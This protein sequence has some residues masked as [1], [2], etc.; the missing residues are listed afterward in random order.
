[1]EYYSYKNC[2]NKMIMIVVEQQ[3]LHP[4]KG[5]RTDESIYNLLKT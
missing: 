2:N 3:S 1:M 4:M 5:N